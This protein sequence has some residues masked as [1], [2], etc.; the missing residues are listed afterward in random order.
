MSKKPKGKQEEICKTN[1]KCVVRACPGSGKTFTVSAKMAYLLKKWEYDHRGIAV[2]SFTN[3]AWEEIQ[4]ELSNSFSI[5]IPIRYPHFLGTIDSFINQF[6]FFPYGHLALGCKIRPKLVGEPIFPWKIKHWDRDPK[7]YFDKVSY[8]MKGDIEPI[9]SLDQF[10]FKWKKENVDGSEDGNY[11]GIREAKEALI[12]KGYVNQSD[13]NY[14]SVKLL[15]NYPIAKT[16]ALRFPY[17][18][19]DEAQD[20]SA[21]QMRI[22]EIL[23]EN[24][25]KDIILVGD[26]DQSIFEWNGAKPELFEEKIKE[27]GSITMN[28][29]WR[30]SQN[31][32]DFTYSLS[33][34]PYKSSSVNK[35]RDY[36]FKPEIW[37][38]DYKDPDFEKIIFDFLE[39]CK[40]KSITHSKDIAIL[41]RSKSLIDQIVLSRNKHSSRYIS[42]IDP[43]IK[44]KYAKELMYSKYLYDNSEFQKSFKLLERVFMGILK[45][46]VIYSD[47]ELSNLIEERG[48]FDFKKEIFGLINLMPK[49]DKTL[50]K[51]LD[52]FK[53]NL[54]GYHTPRI[55]RKI[56]WHLEINNR[57]NNFTFEDVFGYENF[58][59]D[60]ILSTI[61]KV[62]GETF[63]AVLLI[64]KKGSNGPRYSNLLK[65]GRKIKHE[66]LRN[67]YVGITRPKRILVL[68]V[69]SEDKDIWKSFFYPKQRSL[70]D[71][72]KAS[73]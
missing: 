31:I 11:K 10:N 73:V 71:F 58:N 8:D 36:D 18:I 64:L 12:Q 53:E 15:E 16:I 7:Q 28:E 40:F 37:D 43:W 1:G 38:Y 20:T 26:P 29:N 55:K 25:L 51:W 30:S 49:T 22:I 48:Y 59:E 14:F 62:K 24:G 65:L 13:A 5:N 60:Y 72:M 56:K 67:V 61:H 68:A 33:N 42:N 63:D 39:L 69:P 50:I 44:N 17:M 3:V 66:E 47:Y 6:I 32:C 54:E 70:I 9:V 57:F 21:M 45:G 27:W 19:I 41:A 34:L 46:K 23:V 2:I 35:V 4:S 52:K